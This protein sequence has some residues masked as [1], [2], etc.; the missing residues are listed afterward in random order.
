MGV[1]DN[2]PNS[3]LGDREETVK[4]LEDMLER[5]GETP[6]QVLKANYTEQLKASLNYAPRWGSNTIILNVVKDE[7]KTNCCC[8][9]EPTNTDSNV[10]DIPP[11]PDGDGIGDILTPPSPINYLGSY[12][13]SFHNVYINR[14]CPEGYQA[15]GIGYTHEKT[16]TALSTISEEDAN[17]QAKQLAILDNDEFLA[18]ATRIGQEKANREGSCL[19]TLEEDYVVLFA[20]DSTTQ[21]HSGMDYGEFVKNIPYNRSLTLPIDS[22]GNKPISLAHARVG[23]YGASNLYTNQ[24][25]LQITAHNIYSYDFLEL[26]AKF[27]AQ[28]KPLAEMNIRSH[29]EEYSRNTFP[30]TTEQYNPAIPIR[31]SEPYI[32]VKLST[33]QVNSSLKELL[34]WGGIKVFGMDNAYWTYSTARRLGANRTEGNSTEVVGIYGEWFVEADTPS[35]D[36]T[37][38]SHKKSLREISN[39]IAECISPKTEFT[40]GKYSYVGATP[41]V[42]YPAPE[43]LNT[44]QKGIFIEVAM[45]YDVYINGN[46]RH[47]V[48]VVH[49]VCKSFPFYYTYPSFKSNNKFVD[50]FNLLGG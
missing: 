49:A 35:Y 17:E 23:A 37:L 27:E 26:I 14:T 22:N 46:I 1:L 29:T 47:K 10:I 15:N 31:F 18:E 48:R 41:N 2:V 40:L 34:G 32:E 25:S 44:T 7:R 12:T 4:Y 19:V 43:V 50:L 39:A 28:Y 11:L 45:Y 3:T 20:I 24:N 6:F 36:S 33:S 42:P 38:D 9:K 5:L 13:S 30:N 8:C 21:F 16:Y